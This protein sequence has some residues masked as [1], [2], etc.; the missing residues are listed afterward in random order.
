MLFFSCSQGRQTNCL[1]MVEIARYLA[2]QLGRQLVLPQCNTSP[3]GEQ[4]C[5]Q[6]EKIPSQKQTLLKFPLGRVLRDTDLSRCH[7]PIG[8]KKPLLELDDLPVSAVPLNVTCVTIGRAPDEARGLRACENDLASDAQFKAQLAIRFTSHLAVTVDMLRNGKAAALMHSAGH[9]YVPGLIGLLMRQSFGKAFGLCIR[10]RETEGVV[11]MARELQHLT[12][13]RPKQTLCVHWRGED[14]HH[15][16]RYKLSP[17]NVTCRNCHPTPPHTIPYHPLPPTPCHPSPSHSIPPRPIQSCST[18]L[19]PIL[20]QPSRSNPSLV[21][22]L[23]SPHPIPSHLHPLLVF[24]FPTA[25]AIRFHSALPRPP[26]CQATALAARL[27]PYAQS[28]G[29]REVLVLSNARYTPG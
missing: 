12:G 19:H 27:V 1:M 23:I 13:F 18:S 28:V 6:H 5:A 29:A 4:A 11:R 10:P 2:E 9:L 3:Y 14:F 8:K 21:P 22:A 20:S 7:A 24:I 26:P 16:K 15:P 17:Q 25:D